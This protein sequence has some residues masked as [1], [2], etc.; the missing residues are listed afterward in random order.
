M[1]NELGTM[2]PIAS[3]ETINNLDILDLA[4]RIDS[5]ILEIASAASSTRFESKT[6]D[7]TRMKA[8]IER[9]K[10]RFGLYAGDPELDLPKYHPKPLTFPIP[11]AVNRL[12]NRDS[13]AMINLWAALRVEMSYSD[14]GERSTGFKGAD[15]VRIDEMLAKMGKLQEI[16]E[17]DPALDL[18]DVD[19][20]EPPANVSTGQPR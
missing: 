19:R 6:Q 13:Q 8:M 1:P 15:K 9:F 10:S 16:I 7:V 12:E 18:L 20:Q 17:N 5:Y 4:H 14:S 2:D 3:P 11:P